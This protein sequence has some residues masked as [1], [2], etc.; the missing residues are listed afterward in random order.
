MPMSG[1]WVPE[2]FCTHLYM[3]DIADDH[4][5]AFPITLVGNQTADLARFRDNLQ[6]V[7]ARPID[8]FCSLCR[9]SSPEVCRKRILHRTGVDVGQEILIA[10]RL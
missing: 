9:R 6:A 10:A 3:A 1:R 7:L 8:Q 5:S 4:H 2:Y